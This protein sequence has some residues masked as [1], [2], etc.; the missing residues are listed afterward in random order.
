MQSQNLD[1]NFRLDLE[2]YYNSL[3]TAIIMLTHYKPLSKFA[4]IPAPFI[5]NC[6]FLSST[7]TTASVD[8]PSRRRI[9]QI[10]KLCVGHPH[11]P[12]EDHQGVHWR[13]SEP[14]AIQLPASEY[15]GAL[16]TQ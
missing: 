10:L 2:A 5:Q 13:S 16:T 1:Y 6:S 8:P 4:T 12:N 15:N 7:P 3:T 11:S 9:H 14:C